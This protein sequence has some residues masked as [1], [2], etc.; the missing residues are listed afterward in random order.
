MAD[1][2]R[3]A[4]AR[5][6]LLRAWNRY[7]TPL[8][9]A[10]QAVQAIAHVE[11]GGGYGAEGTSDPIWQ[12]SNNWGAIKCPLQSQPC[13]EGCFSHVDT[14]ANGQ[15][16]NY[17]FR[18]YDS[19][20]DGAAG[21]LFELM[22]RPAVAR[23]LASGNA[24]AIANAMKQPPA[25]MALPAASYGRL[26]A[27]RARVVAKNLNEPLYVSLGSPALASSSGD[28]LELGILAFVGWQVWKALKRR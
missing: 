28:A 14:D 5:A 16:G 10:V 17:C 18:K 26:I 1:L 13:G 22:R 19:P 8:P 27:Q 6:F 3:D 20:A 24:T 11:S 23:V 7:G 21:L 25:Y 15:A 2:N 4:W 12:G 9:P